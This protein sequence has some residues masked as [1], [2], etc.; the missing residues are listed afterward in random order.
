VGYLTDTHCHLNLKIF[1]EDLQQVLDRAWERGVKRIL[2]PGI[3]LETS[4]RAIGIAESDP[5]IFAA[6]GVH[7]SEANTWQPGTSRSLR[8]IASHPKVAAIGEI[9][10]DYYRDLAPRTL[11][12]QI[13]RAQLELAVELGKPVSVHNRAAWQDLWGELVRWMDGIPTNS[14]RSPGVLHSFDGEIDQGLQALEK[15]FFLGVSGPVTF[16]KARLH[17]QLVTGLPLAGILIET[18]APYLTPH[19]FRGHRNE[20]SYTYLIVEKIAALHQT[21]PELVAEVTSAN[22]ARLFTWGA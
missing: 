16:T 2:V 15:G 10:L 7:P 12:K 21:S 20:P 4:R 9:G 14:G 3:D 13:F 22:A 18:D 5:R 6:V 11:Q 17:Q 1:Q 8:E 19:P